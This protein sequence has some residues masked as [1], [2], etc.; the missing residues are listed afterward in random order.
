MT[1]AQLVAVRDAAASVATARGVHAFDD[2]IIYNQPGWRERLR[3]LARG[4]R[5]RVLRSY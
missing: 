3:L 4:L 5:Q 1:V 2:F